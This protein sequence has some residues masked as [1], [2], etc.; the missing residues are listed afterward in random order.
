MRLVKDRMQHYGTLQ[1]IGSPIFSPTV[2]QAVNRY[3]ATHVVDWKD[4]DE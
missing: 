3:R 2:G 1:A 4:W